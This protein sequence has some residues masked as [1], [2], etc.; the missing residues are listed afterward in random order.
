MISTEI[1]EII[2]SSNIENVFNIGA[3][4][5]LVLILGSLIVGFICLT[6]YYRIYNNNKR[7]SELKFYEKSIVS[8]IIGFLSI[9]VSL[10]I[11][12]ILVLLTLL[13]K[14]PLENYEKIL[15]QL[16]YLGSFFYF[17]IFLKLNS[18]KPYK[19]L[20]FIKEYILGTGN[21]IF[22]LSFLAIIILF[23]IF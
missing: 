17:I 4:E 1:I 11:L 15:M 8:L 22:G 20:G 3:N 2:K 16:P 12:T 5:F 23:C 7:W 19:E 14:V 6:L 18:N 10:Y 21:L 13:L 9:L